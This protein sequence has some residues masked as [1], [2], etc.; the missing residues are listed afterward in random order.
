MKSCLEGTYSAK[1]IVALQEDIQQ[2]IRKPNEIILIW[3]TYCGLDFSH[4]TNTVNYKDLPAQL[5]SYF[6]IGNSSETF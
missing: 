3:D 4:L 1:V 2:R 6:T 5:H